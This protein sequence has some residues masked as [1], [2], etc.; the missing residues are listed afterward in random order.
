[1][2]AIV[3]LVVATVLMGAGSLPGDVQHRHHRPVF[4]AVALGLVLVFAGAAVWL[5]GGS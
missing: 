4:A 3:V 1:M 2:A 5:G